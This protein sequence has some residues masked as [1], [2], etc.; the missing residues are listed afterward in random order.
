MPL[1]P[2]NQPTNQ[3]VK[4]LL[5]QTPILTYYDPSKPIVISAVAISNGLGGAIFQEENKPLRVLVYAF[6]TLAQTER[7]Y[8]QIE[9]ECLANVWACERFDRYITELDQFRLLT[10][11]K[12]LVPL[13]NTQD[14]NNTPLRCQRLLMRLVPEYIPG[15]FLLVSDALSRNLMQ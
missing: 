7:N 13:I 14:L 15:K 9:K 5:I 6:R 11:H 2:T 1:N 12:P 8:A 3:R 10:D 4:E